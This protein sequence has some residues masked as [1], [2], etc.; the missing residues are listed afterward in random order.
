MRVHVHVC[1]CV[2]ARVGA[3][4]SESDDRR[5]RL[6]QDFHLHFFPRVGNDED[7]MMIMIM[8]DARSVMLMHINIGEQSAGTHLK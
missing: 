3:A 4:E 1:V 2:H 7:G 8:M 5:R 6:M